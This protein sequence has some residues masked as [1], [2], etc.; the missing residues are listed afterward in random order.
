MQRNVKRH[1]MHSR[2]LSRAAQPNMLHNTAQ[3]VVMQSEV[4]M[5]HGQY[6][7]IVIFRF[8][9]TLSALQFSFLI[10]FLET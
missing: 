4:T 3:Q 10:G 2:V 6:S 7:T 8:F 9:C 1:K 5:N